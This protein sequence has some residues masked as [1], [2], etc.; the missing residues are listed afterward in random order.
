MYNNKTTIKRERIF[1]PMGFYDDTILKS[2]VVVEY[3]NYN[4]TL[5][6]DYGIL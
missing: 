6:F 4:P 5:E 2:V 1:L 3:L